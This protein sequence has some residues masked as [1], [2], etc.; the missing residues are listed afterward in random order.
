MGLFCSC[1]AARP[2]A[3]SRLCCSFAFVLVSISR[4]SFAGARSLLPIV[5]VFVF[6]VHILICLH[7]CFSPRC[8]A[9]AVCAQRSDCAL[10]VGVLVACVRAWFGWA[11]NNESWSLWFESFCSP[12]VLYPSSWIDGCACLSA[13]RSC[14]VFC[15]KRAVSR[16][17]FVAW[18]KRMHYP[19]TRSVPFSSC[20]PRASV[21]SSATQQARTLNGTTAVHPPVRPAW[22]QSLSNSEQL[23]VATQHRSTP[24][25]GRAPEKWTK[26]RTRK[27]QKLPREVSA[28][29]VS[30][31]GLRSA[32]RNALLVGALQPAV[33]QDD[34]GSNA[35]RQRAQT[36]QDQR[37]GMCST[38]STAST[39]RTGATG[40][41]GCHLCAR[42]PH[43]QQRR[44]V[45]VGQRAE[46][47]AQQADVTRRLRKAVQHTLVSTSQSPTPRKSRATTTAQR[48]RAK[49]A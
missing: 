42:R 24:C 17:G 9:P 46:I 41:R 1:S 37:A 22:P 40:A 25:K 38:P 20:H 45:R 29:H 13:S 10:W 26:S 16:I 27:L 21:L 43:A 18:I 49:E 30:E 44:T 11:G 19:Q 4:P 8:C 6:G 12:F 36:A 23:L 7:L 32:R 48:L 15:R 3:P 5:V 39:S 47:D 28:K 34:L 33:V 31:A 14:F 2:F 35:Q